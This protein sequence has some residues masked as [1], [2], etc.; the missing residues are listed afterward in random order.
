MLV[1]K[2]DLTHPL[3]WTVENVLTPEE[4]TAL[5]KQIDEAGPKLA[6]VNTREG[7]V[8][9]E[10]L[11][12]NERIIIDDAALAQRMYQRALHSIPES[13]RGMALVGA[14]ERL[15][16]YRY[17]KGQYFRPHYDGSFRRNDQERSL[18]TFIIYLNE[19]FEGGQTNFP[20]LDKIIEPRPG[21]ALLF[22]HHVLHEGVEVT[23]GLKYAVRSDIMYAGVPKTTTA[24]W[25]L[26][27]ITP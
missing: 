4:C 23:K 16:C 15:R 8:L 12:N 14:N 1:S 6:T 7:H 5:I 9:R 24:P 11:R 22:Q 26:P 2:L 18:L 27:S 19:G 3:V 20:E 21:L 13:S 17:S 10:S 25:D